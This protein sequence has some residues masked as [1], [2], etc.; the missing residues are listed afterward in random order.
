[1]TVPS[2]TKINETLDGTSAS[3]PFPLIKVET[4]C[5][6][7]QQNKNAFFFGATEVI[8][9]YLC[10]GEEKGGGWHGGW[11]RRLGVYDLVVALFNSQL[12]RFLSRITT[13]Q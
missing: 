4:T 10:Y 13:V 12:G 5:N 11:V 3:I 6:S 2:Q 1:M 8:H 9:C 7:K